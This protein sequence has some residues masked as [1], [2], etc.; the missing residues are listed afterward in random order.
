MISESQAIALLK[1]YSDDDASFEKVLSHSKAVQQVALE[2]VDDF[3]KNGVSVTRELIKIGSLLHDIGRLKCFHNQPKQCPVIHGILGGE[4]LRKEGLDEALALI[5]ERHIGAGILKEEITLFKL[6][7]P[8][9]DFVPKSAEE[10]IITYADNLIFGSELKTFDDVLN[11]FINQIG[12]FIAGRFLNLHNFIMSN[13]NKLEQ[14]IDVNKLSM[15]WLSKYIDFNRQSE[16][17]TNLLNKF[18]EINSDNDKVSKVRIFLN[19]LAPL[20]LV[21]VEKE[22]L[23]GTFLDLNK[24]NGFSILIDGRFLDKIELENLKRDFTLIQANRAL[25]SEMMLGFDEIIKR[26]KLFFNYFR[27]ME[28]PF[29]FKF[30]ILHSLISFF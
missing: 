16:I 6:P 14:V 3:L 24:N 25:L 10:K 17:F 26:P 4:I 11:R 29:G 13:S 12:F 1:K 28:V 9:Q 5:C 15:R 7:L 2:I 22:T 18:V 23:F 19:S 27:K 20:R 8:E 30:K 21:L